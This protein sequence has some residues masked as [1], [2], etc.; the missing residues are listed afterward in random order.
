MKWY[1]WVALISWCWSMNRLSTKKKM[2]VCQENERQ[3]PY[4][5]RNVYWYGQ[6]QPYKQCWDYM[7]LTTT[8]QPLAIITIN[9]G[10]DVLLL[11]SVGFFH[12]AASRNQDNDGME[13]E[14]PNEEEKKDCL[15]VNIH[16][17]ESEVK[18]LLFF[19][20]TAGQTE[21]QWWNII[22]LAVVV[23]FFG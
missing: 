18:I 2:C 5:K 4:F 21:F 19:F 7:P 8:P 9:T 17:F 15:H 1:Y 3:S 20:Y 11:S 14:K 6:P 22:A 13:K 12:F 23:L 10:I 16:L